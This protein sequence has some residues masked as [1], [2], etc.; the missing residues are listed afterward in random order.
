MKKREV[1]VLNIQSGDSTKD[2][3]HS[4][5]TLDKN[6]YCVGREKEGHEYW[7]TRYEQRLGTRNNCS[8]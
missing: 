1:S 3:W 5:W 6:T 4:N 7:Q 2:S 8:K